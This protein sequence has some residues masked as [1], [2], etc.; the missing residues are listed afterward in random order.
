L[1][2]KNSTGNGHSNMAVYMDGCYHFDQVYQH[3]LR[4]C[5]TEEI[6]DSSYGYEQSNRGRAFHAS[7]Y[8]NNCTTQIYGNPDMYN[9]DF[10]G[11]PGRTFH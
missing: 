6:C 3:H 11:S 9:S 5:C 8:V 7:A 4:I 1:P 2:D 10:C